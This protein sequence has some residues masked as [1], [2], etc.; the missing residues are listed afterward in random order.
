[1]PYYPIYLDI[2]NKRCIVAGGGRVGERKVERLLECGAHVVVI[3]RELT[4]LLEKMKGEGRI[5]HI[6]D[7]YGDACL[8]GAFIVIG[9]TNRDDVN[10]R[11]A[12]EAERRGIMVNIVDD[13]ARCDFILPSL[14]QRGDLVI[15]LSTGG[16]SPALAKKLR[17]DMEA[18]FGPEYGIFLEIMGELR[19]AAIAG[20]C[21]SE[22]NK[23][24]F[25]LLVKSDILRL[26]REKNRE[27]VRICIR[28]ITGLD[29]DLTGIG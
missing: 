11:I 2:T 23:K 24:M 25:E 17:E 3:S 16:K 21:P 10:K 9:A 13:P 12:R 18:S 4:P 15:A 28:D 5:D 29:V 22:D 26:I 6:D 1:M 7:D 14:V 8:E 27:G 20:G 19:K